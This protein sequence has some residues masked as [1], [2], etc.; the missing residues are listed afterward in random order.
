MGIN[1]GINV[2]EVEGKATPSIQPAAT[3][4]TG[5]VIQSERGIPNQPVEITS[6][7]QFV[8]RFGSFKD[9]YY[10]A[11][12][13][14][15]FFENGGSNAV[16]VRVLNSGTGLAAII[17]ETSAPWDLTNVTE[18]CL[19]I[20]IQNGDKSEILEINFSKKTPACQ[21]STVISDINSKFNVIGQELRITIDGA[22]SPETYTFS[23]QDFEGDAT[24][25][26]IA[27]A[28]NRGF[29][30]LGL[31]AWVSTRK[32]GEGDEKLTKYYLKICSDTFGEGSSLVVS[33]LSAES[34][35]EIL[36]F[37][38][39]ETRGSGNVGNLS[40]VNSDELLNVLQKALEKHPVTVKKIDDG[41]SSKI[42]IEQNDPIGTLASG[43]SANVVFKFDSPTDGQAAQPASR[44]FPD[45]SGQ[46][47]LK[48]TAGY[49]S[50]EDPG[51][52]G[53]S[54]QIK[55]AKNKKDN[56]LFDLSVKNQYGKIVEIWEKINPDSSFMDT[57]NNPSTGSKYI[58]LFTYKKYPEHTDE[59]KDDGF[60]KLFERSGGTDY[61]QEGL[62]GQ[63]TDKANEATALAE[64]FGL[65]ETCNIQLLCCPEDP[66][67]ENLKQVIRP[68]LDHASKMGDRMFVGHVPLGYDVNA[69]AG[70]IGNLQTDKSYGALYFPWIKVADPQ[71]NYIPIPPTGHILGVYARTAIER[72]IWKAPAGN[73]ARLRGVIDVDQHITD[74]DHTRLVKD[75]SVNAVRS[76]KGLGIVIDS[77]RTLSTN[78]LW[79]YVNVRRLFNYVESSLKTGLRW[80]VQEPN[81]DTLWNKIK[82]NSVTPFLMGLWKRGA[83]GPGTPEQVFTVRVDA[84][85]N[86]PENIQQGLLNVDIY[87]YSSRPAEA[88]VISV[89]QQ[90]GGATVKES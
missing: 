58:K 8:E 80:V 59:S 74:A 89:G 83:F 35:D 60:V 84:E 78:P 11:Y 90:E 25:E 85:N 17:A 42:K 62:D 68:G 72:G 48:V 28:I 36:K 46:P 86:P 33:G 24:L 15:G 43:G 38:E 75:S 1:L 40:K 41:G 27:L 64:A 26:Q 21:E 49:R 52:W 23:N 34:N 56:N 13:V 73:A 54:I 45:N 77:S 30:G 79:L 53:N 70:W 51:A 3:S 22:A 2:I 32:E 81:D 76:I 20:S 10:G 9:D 63:F 14:K 31:G 87:F 19:E 71:G 47:A 82:Y 61:G 18:P 44:T 7:T 5:F 57:V 67:N 6:W 12:A 39:N 66:G 69:I 50:E 88:I 37:N 55:I 29:P 65:F 16:V 4:V